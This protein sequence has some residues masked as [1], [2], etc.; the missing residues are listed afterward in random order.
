MQYRNLGRSGLKV[1]ELSFGAWVTFAN[2]LEVKQAI[3]LMALAYDAG[4]NFFD[5][6]ET[7]ADGIAEQ[8]MGKA[9]RK[10]S[11]PRDS[12]LVSSKVFWGGRLPTQRGLSRKHIHDAC[13]AA[14]KR[15][16]VDYLDMFFCHRPDHETPI[17]ET[18]RAMNTLIEQGKVL[19]WGTSEWSAE[20]IT[21]AW[22]IA[23]R[24]NLI[25]PTM[26]Q[27]QYNMLHRERVEKE[28]LPV[29]KRFGLGTTIWSPLA[30]GVLTGKYND[31][32]PLGSRATLPDYEW[33]QKRIQSEDGEKKLEKVRA[34][35]ELAL[36]FEIPLPQLAIA[37]CLRNDDV[38]TAIL[39]AS[40]KEQLSAN[41]ASAKRLSEIDAAS[42]IKVEEILANKPEPD[43]L[44]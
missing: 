25:G 7:Y 34:L 27:P 16:Q 29:F 30:S 31:A 38:S 37:W 9:L 36:Q 35:V 23:E 41:L 13:H 39:G 22:G 2:Q 5:N 15:L 12:Y 32:I 6:A 33:L 10:L 1:S 42:W 26:E 18:V 19:Y 3:E 24:Y 14:L 20:E 8:I 44:F 28:Y 43:P 4:V 11:W 21:A 40:N 17:A